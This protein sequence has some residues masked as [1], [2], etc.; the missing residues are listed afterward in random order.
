MGAPS[1]TT[2]KPRPA[3][4]SVK[5]L[6]PEN[7]RLLAYLRAKAGRPDEKGSAWWDE[8][9]DFLRKNPIRLG[10]PRQA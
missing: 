6:R 2:R 7:R 5:H 9:R 1:M 10:T 8:F 3:K 4:S